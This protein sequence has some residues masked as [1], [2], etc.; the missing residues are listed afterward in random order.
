MRKKR[1]LF[2]LRGIILGLVFGLLIGPF[3]AVAQSTNTDGVPVYSLDELYTLALKEAE[4]IKLAKENLYL[5]KLDN[6]KA[7]SVLIPRFSAFGSYRHYDEEKRREDVTLQPEWS[8]AYGV[9]LDQSFTLNGRELTAYEISKDL[10]E[11]ETL[12]LA[13]VQEDLLI[14]TAAAY[15]DVLNAEKRLEITNANVTRLNTQ[16]DSVAVRL[17]LETVTRPDLLRVE[18][19]RSQALTGQIQ[20]QNA[21][22]LANARLAAICGLEGDFRLEEVDISSELAADPMLADIIADAMVQR[23]DIQALTLEKEIADKT[24]KYTKGELWPRLAVEGVWANNDADPSSSAPV[25]ETLYGGISL[26]FTLFDGGLRKANI[27]ESES[28]SRQA[29]LALDA[30]NKQVTVDANHAYLTYM[31]SKSTLKAFADELQFA[32][33]NFDAVNIQFEYGLAN[34]VDVID[35][36]T[37]L[38]TAEQQLIEAAFRSRLALLQIDRVRGQLLEE[39]LDRLGKSNDEHK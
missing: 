33:E 19:E 3:P 31:A 7:R 16:R 32:K 30:A 25:D 38:V 26:N 17:E 1:C 21:I 20:A 14:Q 8:S 29:Q 36:N 12:D 15:Y 27:L 28:R 39:T 6:R 5:A 10:I 11:K 22:L 35:A 18:A 23:T 37:L 9:R 4:L 24:V 2:G 34:S 13:D